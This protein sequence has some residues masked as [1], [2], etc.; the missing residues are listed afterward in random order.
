MF[1]K[2]LF[3]LLVAIVVFLPSR[4]Q[5][6]DITNNTD[7]YFLGVHLGEA[8]TKTE[9]ADFGFGFSL[10]IWGVYLDCMIAPPEYTNDNHIVDELW[11]DDETFSIN[12]GYQIPL[13]S[14]SKGRIA[15]API[16]GYSQCNYGW[17]DAST[18]NLHVEDNGNVTN[19]HDYNV[20]KRYHEF[21]YGVGLFV[22]PISLFEIY[23][24]YSRRGIYGGISFNLNFLADL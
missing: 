20:V 24:V 10:A 17:T 12:L 22:Q 23:G 15:V 14:W 2:S 6:L 11:Q 5:L 21:N 1:K 18:L 19:T 8:G 16:V 3:V 4:A 9:Y 13:V 7:R